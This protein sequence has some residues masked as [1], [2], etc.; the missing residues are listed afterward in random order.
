[1]ADWDKIKQDYE[2]GMS[3]QELADK[4][5][6]KASTIRVR[7]SRNKWEAKKKPKKKNETLQKDVT[8]NVTDDVTL[9]KSVTPINLPDELENN[10]SLND[11]QKAFCYYFLRYHHAYKAYVKAYQI[12]ISADDFNRASVDSSAY[13][14]LRKPEIKKYIEKIRKEQ[15][16]ELFAD[17]SD[18]MA[19]NLRIMNADIS[20]YISIDLVKKYRTTGFG[21]Q[22][23]T[24]L[25]TNGKPIVDKYNQIYVKNAEGLDW[26]LVS[27]VH[28][29]KD[30]LVVKLNDKQKAMKELK[31]FLPDAPG[32]EKENALIQAISKSFKDNDLITKDD[33]DE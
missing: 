22:E 2:N 15:S 9:H 30:G 33:V 13:E 16:K 21:D 19:E 18:V 32:E 14:N 25:D 6:V 23:E 28:V 11:K 12:D 24:V 10:D 26:S 7:R 4:Y 29:G 17:L 20:D 8:K 3:Y 1:M 5:Q 27:E 31:D